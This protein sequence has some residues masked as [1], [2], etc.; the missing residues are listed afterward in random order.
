MAGGFLS[1]RSSTL[2]GI[3]VLAV[4]DDPDTLYLLEFL[5]SDYG[6]EVVT[7]TSAGEALKKLL[8]SKPDILII[9]I[10]M[11]EKDGY[12]LIREIRNLKSDKGETPAIAL[13]ASGFETESAQAIKAG[14]EI[15]LHKPFDLT[16]LVM[17][18]A[19]LVK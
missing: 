13:T 11:P 15:L 6:A 9:D 7:V 14:F 1:R 18:V 3:R 17:T 10:A 8:Q 19:Q 12:W 4:D 5:L 16:D 2:K